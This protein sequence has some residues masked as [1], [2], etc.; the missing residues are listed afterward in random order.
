MG[1]RLGF[2]LLNGNIFHLTRL[3]LDNFTAELLQNLIFR[4]IL[5]PTIVQHFFNAGCKY[6]AAAL[7]RN[8]NLGIAAGSG[9]RPEQAETN[10]PQDCRLPLG[11]FSNFI[12]R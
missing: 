4:A 11:Q 6:S 7:R 12:W 1:F 9:N 2:P 10:Q 5:L 8:F 3:P